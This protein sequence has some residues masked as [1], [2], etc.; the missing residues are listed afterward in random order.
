MASNDFHK[1][2]KQMQTHS[3]LVVPILS[4]NQFINVGKIFSSFLGQVQFICPISVLHA[5]QFTVNQVEMK[6]TRII[7]KQ[8]ARALTNDWLKDYKR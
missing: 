4:P 1:F 6:F 3:E 7:L 2:E 8:F 5:I